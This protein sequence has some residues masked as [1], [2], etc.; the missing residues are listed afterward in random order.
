MLP[1][2]DGW[3]EYQ[4]KMAKRRALCLSNHGWKFFKREGPHGTYYEGFGPRG[5][6]VMSKQLADIRDAFLAAINHAFDVQFPSP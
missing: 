3:A 4:W 2:D 6:R 5:R 1:G